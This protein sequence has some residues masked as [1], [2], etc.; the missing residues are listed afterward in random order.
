MKLQNMIRTSVLTKR[1]SRFLC[2]YDLRSG[3]FYNLPIISQWQQINSLFSA[4][5]GD[6]LNGIASCRAFIDTPSNF[7][8]ADTFK[9]HLRSFEVTNFFSANNLGSKRDRDMQ[10]V[11]LRSSSQAASNDVQFDI[12][13][14][15]CEL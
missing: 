10:L 14:S 2:V 1:I 5:A 13:G 11:S 3:H 8:F 7:F 12:V 9:G 15:L 4:S 6:Y